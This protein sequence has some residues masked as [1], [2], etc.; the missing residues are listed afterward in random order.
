MQ[1]SSAAKV[2]SR[3]FITL[4]LAL[5]VATSHAQ[6][7]TVLH[8]FKGTDGALPLGVL[9][10]DRAG[11][12]Y[13]TSNVG[14]PATTAGGICG[15]SRCGTV[16]VLNKAGK[17]IGLYSFSGGNGYFPSAGLLRD[18]E[19]NFYGTTLAGGDTNC[20]ELGCGTVFKLSSTGKE[21][22]L[23]E[24]KGD[25]DGF[26]PAAL[27]VEDAEGNLYGTTSEGGGSGGLGTVF[28]LDPQGNETILHTFSGGSDGCSP[29]PGVILDSTGN[30]YGVAAQG[31][32]AFCNNGYGTVYKLDTSNNFTVL[33]T[34]DGED[35]S[36]PNSVLLFDSEGNLYGTT[37]YGGTGPDCADPTGCG[38]V[39]ELS[40]QQDG[41]WAE[42]VLYDFCSLSDCADGEEPI[43]GPL[44][45]DAM[46]NLYGT[47]YF[48]GAYPNC[49]GDP[50]GVVFELDTTGKETVLHSFTGGSGGSEPFAGLVLDAAGNL[51]GTA[52]FGG[53][54]CLQDK[55]GCGVVFKITP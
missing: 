3:I 46:G 43:A 44:A 4:S 13:G 17:E 15:R 20:L 55:A 12:I 50:C 37:E 32:F 18:A 10:L 49:N 25:L 27:L 53:A 6:T 24:F 7:F 40:P 16:F 22:V 52:E 34:F 42:K 2:V 1:T 11:N 5:A 38:T 35:G 31:G 23:Y 21:Q 28:K 8:T 36:F 30:L 47:T 19:G 54:Q 39:F 48:G 45:R 33:Y 14:G 51:Y 41:S 9:L 26:Y 29:N